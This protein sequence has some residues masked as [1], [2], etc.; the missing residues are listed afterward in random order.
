MSTALIHRLIPIPQMSLRI[1]I[2]VALGVAFLALLSQLSIQIGVV[3]LT[4]QTLGVLL[5]GAAYGLNLGT[6][7]LICYLLLGGMG[8]GVFASGASGWAVFTG[9]TAG[10]LVGF[11]F[12]AALVGF[13][14]QRGWDRRFSTTA[15]AMLLGNIVIYACGLVWLNHLIADWGKTIQVGFLPFLLGDA[16]KIVIAAT[17]LPLCWRF[18][19]KPEDNTK[20]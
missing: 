16:I 6:L 18:L 12:A 7:T 20:A 13:L 4:G 5:I 9:A 14:A 1:P 3:P 17:L 19:G 2:Q 10:Y 11:I 8:L 15:L